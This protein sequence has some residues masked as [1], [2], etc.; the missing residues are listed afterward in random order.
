MGECDLSGEE[1]VVARDVGLR[2][3]CSML[4]L[5]IHAGPELL[6]VEGAR[7]PVD[8][9]LLANGTRIVRT[10]G[11]VSHFMPLFRRFSR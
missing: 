3:A 11:W 4:K 6:D 10:E 5:D 7:S 8:A 9:E 1:R 2:I